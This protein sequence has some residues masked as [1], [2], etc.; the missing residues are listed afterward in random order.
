MENNTQIN[1]SDTLSK[2]SSYEGT[3][4]GFCMENNIK[5][6]QL[7]YQ[8]RKVTRDNQPVFHGIKVNKKDISYPHVP[9]SEACLEADVPIKIEL[10]KATIYIPSNDK[11]ALENVLQIVMSTC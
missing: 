2:F 6:H 9:P 10:G 11:L 7:Y 3:I 4:A 8:R 1:W 5:P